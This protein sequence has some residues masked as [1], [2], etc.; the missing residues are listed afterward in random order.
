M[1][2]RKMSWAAGF[3][4]AAA[5]VLAGC[6]GGGGGG[7]DTESISFTV[8][9][10]PKTYA[11]NA[12][13]GTLGGTITGIAAEAST[14]PSLIGFVVDGMLTGTYTVAA[15]TLVVTYTNDAGTEFAAVN[16]VAGSGSV[17]ITSFGAVGGR[18]EGTF[19]AVVDDGAST[20]LD[21]ISGTFSVVREPDA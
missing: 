18:I 8:D 17:T 20:T 4:L 5:V 13:G 16:G 15:N 6:D 1:L 3:G 19:F 11:T 21:I 9:G 14:G 7:A 2:G 10:T 12:A